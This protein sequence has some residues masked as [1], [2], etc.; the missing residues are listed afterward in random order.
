MKFCIL[1]L[2]AC[3][4]L[5]SHCQPL[6]STPKTA[7]ELYALGN[8]AYT[9]RSH[10]A[11]LAYLYAYWQKKGT[12]NEQVINVISYLD[13]MLE[14]R[15]PCPDCPPCPGDQV[16][17]RTSA[18]IIGPPELPVENKPQT[19]PL[20]IRGMENADFEIITKGGASVFKLYFRRAALGVGMNQERKNQLKPL[21]AA[22]LDRP[23]GVGEP[24]NV[25]IEL[26]NNFRL[27]TK[28]GIISANYSF[29]NQLRRGTGTLTL[30]AYNNGQGSLVSTTQFK[31]VLTKSK[32]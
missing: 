22:W 20:V 32:N 29:F 27:S 2:L 5:S 4:A 14:I 11:A 9:R 17:S 12:I 3:T 26:P 24:D 7:A 31:Q 13:R 28:A 21:E 18:L 10:P 25:L 15:T 6:I 8:E 1:L 19:Y 16:V 23:I 30:D